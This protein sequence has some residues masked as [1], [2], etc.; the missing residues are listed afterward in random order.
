MDTLKF[1]LDFLETAPTSIYK[2]SFIEH[3]G[4]VVV[5]RK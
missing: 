1:F 2:T 4:D 3:I 5:T